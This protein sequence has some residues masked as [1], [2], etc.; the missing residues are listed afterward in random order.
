MEQFQKMDSL[1]YEL[2][3]GDQALVEAR[4]GCLFPC[5]FT[6]YEVAASQEQDF[7]QFGLWVGFGST[8]I[9]VRKEF[10][11]YPVISLVGDIGGS[12]GLFVGFSFFMVWDLLKDFITFGGRLIC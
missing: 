4:S 5:T 3:T 2:A 8:V 9:T 12:L 11:V 1:Y 7:G 10:Y 6:R